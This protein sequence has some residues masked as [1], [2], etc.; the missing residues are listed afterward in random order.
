MVVQIIFELG[1]AGAGKSHTGPFEVY[2]SGVALCIT[3]IILPAPAKWYFGPY[4]INF[5]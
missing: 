1:F 5:T 2:C 3:P 4:S